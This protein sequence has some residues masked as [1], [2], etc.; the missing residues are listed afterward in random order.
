VVGKA[1]ADSEEELLAHF[2]SVATG[3][4]RIHYWPPRG[5]D[6]DDT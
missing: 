5:R 1:N 3:A 4:W 2:K 6:R